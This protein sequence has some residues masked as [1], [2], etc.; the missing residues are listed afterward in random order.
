M[1]KMGYIHI[2]RSLGKADIYIEDDFV[3]VTVLINATL[4]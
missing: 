3:K 4:L 1:I 2:D